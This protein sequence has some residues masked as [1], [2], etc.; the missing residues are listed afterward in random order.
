VTTVAGSQPLACSTLRFGNLDMVQQSRRRLA[1]AFREA[2][3]EATRQRHGLLVELETLQTDL[4]ERLD[5]LDQRV[6]EVLKQWNG[7]RQSELAPLAPEA[8]SATAASG[9]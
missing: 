3:V 9:S 1:K 7:S 8:H 2:H 4:L 6:Y 5:D